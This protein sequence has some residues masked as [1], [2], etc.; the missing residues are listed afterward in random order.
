MY[1]TFIYVFGEAGAGGI[2]FDPGGNLVTY[3]TW[4]IGHR[5]N[6]EAEWLALLLGLDPIRKNNISNLIVFGDS[7]QVIQKMRTSYN[8]GTAKFRRIHNRIFCLSINIQVSYFHI[9]KG[10][11]IEADK[12]SNQG[13]RNELG[14]V[15]INGYKKFQTYPLMS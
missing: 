7:K 6:N 8:H 1:V 15:T 3:Y 10:N 9:L 13:L 11:N 14:I 12:F 4:G 2:I 5:T